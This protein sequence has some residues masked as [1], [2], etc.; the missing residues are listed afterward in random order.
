MPISRFWRLRPGEEEILRKAA[1]IIRKQKHRHIEAP[2]TID[3]IDRLVAI[4]DTD[5]CWK[6]G[7]R[8]RGT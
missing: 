2:N 8:K 3:F 1:S 5:P 7:G 4:Q 6:R